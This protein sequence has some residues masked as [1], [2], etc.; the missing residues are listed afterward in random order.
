M[1]SRT[2]LNGWSTKD[3]GQIRRTAPETNRVEKRQ[4]FGNRKS[5]ER[6]FIDRSPLQGEVR[7]VVS[8]LGLQ[9]V[10]DTWDRFSH[11]DNGGVYPANAGELTSWSYDAGSQTIEST[12][13]SAMTFN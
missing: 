11:A 1:S 12:I 2:P 6:T 8:E 7:I 10:F 9:E 5:V 3:V 4:D 13:K